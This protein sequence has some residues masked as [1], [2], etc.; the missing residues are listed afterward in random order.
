MANNSFVT[1]AQ[2][3]LM[4]DAHTGTAGGAGVGFNAGTLEIYDGTQPANADTAT[5]SGNHLLGTYSFAAQG[6]GAASAS[7][8]NPAIATANAVT[9]GNASASGTA[10]WARAK[11]SGGAVLQDFSVGTSGCDI[12]F[13]SATFTNGI[14][15]PNITSFLIT[16]PLKNGL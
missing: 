15:M 3:K 6:F 12:N 11:K 8:G 7:A 10:T 5:D 13:T 16:A 4:L 1:T 2:E 14:S 9:G